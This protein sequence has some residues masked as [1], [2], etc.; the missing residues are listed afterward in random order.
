[1]EH[2]IGQEIMIAGRH[3]IWLLVCEHRNCDGCFFIYECKTGNRERV[4][5]EYGD[6]SSLDRKDGKN[7]IFL[8]IS[9]NGISLNLRRTV[10]S[11][12]AFCQETDVYEKGTGVYFT[13]DLHLF[14]DREF[15]Y[16]PRGFDN[17]GDM[18]A[19]IERRWNETIGKGDHVYVL[20][21]LMLGGTSNKGIE[22]L[23]R[24]NGKIHIVIGNHDTDNRVK[25]YQSLPNVSSVTY[26]AKVK[27]DGYNFYLTHFPCLT[28]SLEKE[29]LK[30]MSLNLSG[31]TH[32][33]DK[34]YND[35]PYVYNVAVDAHG[36]KPVAIEKIIS[37]MR[38]KVDECK[39]LL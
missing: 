6:C 19:E 27:Y 2:Q 33:K 12:N 17:V 34:F 25:L 3:N 1:M 30:Q 32:S 10:A 24:L 16:K 15:I 36:C 7:I 23:S 11:A 37:D 14:H 18:N 38:A 5:R 39:K 21:D 22:I 29:S 28:G 31:H 4:K 26:A 9:D 8:P 13:S 35:L 20:G